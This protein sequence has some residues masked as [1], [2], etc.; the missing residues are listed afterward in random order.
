MKGVAC[1]YNSWL[2]TQRWH[3]DMARLG[4]RSDALVRGD[5]GVAPDESQ[6]LE[7]AAE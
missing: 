4:E 7:V 6:P 2:H 3:D 1:L 5:V